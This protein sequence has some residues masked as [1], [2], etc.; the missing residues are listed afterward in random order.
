MAAA[1]ERRA[2]HHVPDTTPGSGCGAVRS[3]VEARSRRGAVRAP[4]LVAERGKQFSG[5]RLERRFVGRVGLGA[6]VANPRGWRLVEA[7]LVRL[8]GRVGVTDVVEHPGLELEA[9]ER[10]HVTE[11]SSRIAPEIL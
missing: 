9:G 6:P 11:R 2:L 7:L 5:R 8:A 3:Q 10:A 4:H 1:P